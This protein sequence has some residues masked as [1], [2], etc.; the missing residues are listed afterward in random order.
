MPPLVIGNP[1]A[2]RSTL[3]RRL[4]ELLVAA[5]EAGPVRQIDRAAGQVDLLTVDLLEANDEHRPV[6]LAEDG[7]AYLNDVVGPDGEEAAE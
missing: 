6:R 3:P 4:P 5:P 2:T 7:R 1:G